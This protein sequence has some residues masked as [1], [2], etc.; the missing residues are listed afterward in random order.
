MKKCEAYELEAFEHPYE[1]DYSSMKSSQNDSLRAKANKL[2]EINNNLL[3]INDNNKPKNIFRNS[4]NLNSINSV[5]SLPNNNNTDFRLNENTKKKLEKYIES[6]Q[7]K[8]QNKTIKD[9]VF[10]QNI[11]I[12]KNAH[13]K[14]HNNINVYSKI[15]NYWEIRDKKNKVKMQQI[16]K[17]REQ[18]IYGELSQKPK[19]S[20]NSQEIIERLKERSY[21]LTEE[22]GYEDEINMNIPIRTKEKN[23]FFKTVYYSNKKKLKSKNRTKITQSVSKINTY[24]EKNKLNKIQT[25]KKRAKTPK[26]KRQIKS[27]NK[28]SSNKKLNFSVADIK[29]LELI[30]QIR[31]KEQDEKMKEIKEKIKEEENAKFVDKDLKDENDV[32]LI[33]NNTNYNMNKS[34]NVMSMRN[35]SMN[36]MSDIITSRKF[37]NE[38]YNRDKKIINHSFILNSS[39]VPKSSNINQVNKEIKSISSFHNKNN[40]AINQK[41]NLRTKSENM[42]KKNTNKNCTGYGLYDPQSKSLK[43]RHFTEISNSYNNVKIDNDKINESEINSKKNMNNVVQSDNHRASEANKDYINNKIKNSLCFEF[44]R[45]L[46]EKKGEI[47]QIYKNELKYRTNE[48]KKIEIELNERNM[49][50][51]QLI[52]ESQNEDKDFQKIILKNQSINH[53]LN[54]MNN[55]YLLKFREENLKRLSEIRQKE[56]KNDLNIFLNIKNEEEKN[57]DVLQNKINVMKYKS[58]LNNEQQNIENNL[59]LYNNEL[60]INKEKKKALLTKIFN[61]KYSKSLVLDNDKEDYDNNEFQQSMDKYLVKNDIIIKE[62][63]ANKYFSKR[64]NDNL[65]RT[66]T[67]DLVSNFDFQRRH[68]F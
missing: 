45:D 58:I 38:L 50:N 28:K 15:S 14:N 11:K 6:K 34:M 10:K 55:E 29:N 59:E 4:P 60:K 44:D 41:K 46:K 16:K 19:I 42:N 7:T 62:N 1:I 33:N 64:T 63:F 43:Y 8:K 18:K 32:E 40:K 17:E 12:S 57:I 21:E 20:K 30:Q 39:S 5:Q 24:Y 68:H 48:I 54:K 67:E 36:L 47:N 9:K 49:I 13:K 2:K 25:S 22:D 51:K 3:G 26:L 37:L 65:N 53:Q 35:Y 52:K 66:E 31:N 61:N 56:N 27:K 23:Y